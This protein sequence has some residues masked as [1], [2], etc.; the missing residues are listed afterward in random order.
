[1]PTTYDVTEI[2][3]LDYYSTLPFMNMT[4]AQRE[5]LKLERKAC[6]HFADFVTSSISKDILNEST[7]EF[8]AKM[9]SFAHEL[10]RHMGA[11]S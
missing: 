6:L 3:D 7:D 9:D 2:K 5:D 10:K 1:V 11:L 8:E 4:R